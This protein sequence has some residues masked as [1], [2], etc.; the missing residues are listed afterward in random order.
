MGIG[1]GTVFAG[2]L[3]DVLR[4][5]DGDSSWQDVYA[6]EAVIGVAAA[7]IAALRDADP[8]AGTAGFAAGFGGVVALRR[9]DGWL[10]LALAY[11]AFGFMYLLVFA[12]LV[13]R[14]RTTPRSAP[15]RPA[16][17]FSL[18]GVAAIAGGLVLGPVSDRFGRRETLVGAFATFGLATV[19]ILTGAQPW[20]ALG[21]VG[22]GMSFSGVPTV[23]AAYVV[24]AT[25][26]GDLRTRV[27]RRH[28]RVRRRPDGRAPGRRRAGR[29][30][31]LLHRR[32]LAQHRHRCRRCRPVVAPPA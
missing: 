1:V 17:T 7:T 29:L 13:A 27:Q 12:F 9:I 24:D 3:A 31:R 22:V 16:S 10:H 14:L 5:R 18:V 19:A 25:D 2:W 21:A 20:V 28:P 11:A 23:I 32:V 6:I 15:P 30:A 8:R 26:A 4:Q